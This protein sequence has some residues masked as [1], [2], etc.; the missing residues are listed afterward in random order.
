MKATTK[1]FWCLAI[2]VAFS[3]ILLA[4][5]NVDW[6][7][8]ADFTNYKTYAWGKGTPV[9]NQLMDQRIID[10]VD[11]QLSAKG[12]QKT[13]D[14]ANADLIVIY[15]AAVGEETQIYTSGTGGYGWGWQ[16]GGGMSTTTVNKIPTGELAVDIGDAKTKK[17]LWLGNANDTLSDKPEKNVDKINK[18]VKKMFEKFPP[19]VKK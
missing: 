17:L 13:D 11:K 6:D 7:K 12:M 5:V 3:G 15:H 2:L 19:P 4:K 18:A 9:K 16:W 1:V 10:A 8:S 14:A